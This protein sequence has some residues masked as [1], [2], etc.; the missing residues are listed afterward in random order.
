MSKTIYRFTEQETKNMISFAVAQGM[1]GG[2]GAYDVRFIVTESRD[3]HDRTIGP[4]CYEVQCE[5]EERTNAPERKPGSM[6]F[7]KQP[8]KHRR[9]FMR[10]DA[11]PRRRYFFFGPRFFAGRFPFGSGVFIAARRASSG[12]TVNGDKSGVFSF[13]F[14][15]KQVY[16]EKF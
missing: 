2:V 1:N 14:I 5:A 11:A 15:D 7:P 9:S 16:F 12:L 13:R 3:A 4:G 8:V 10:S 6:H